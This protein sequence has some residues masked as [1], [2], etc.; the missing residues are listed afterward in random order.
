MSDIA[1]HIEGEREGERGGE[2][3]KEE[4]GERRRG[5]GEGRRGGVGREGKR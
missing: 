4:N 1:S 3:G 2:K 5:W